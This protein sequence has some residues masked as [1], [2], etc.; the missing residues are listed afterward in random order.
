MD[1]GP[2]RIPLPNRSE[3]DGPG[4]QPPSHGNTRQ[5]NQDTNRKSPEET[6]GFSC[7][8]ENFGGFTLFPA[9]ALGP[10]SDREKYIFAALVV[11]KS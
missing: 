8:F 3:H 11:P 5:R 7:Q 10:G 2:N 9:N 1:M 4:I 6:P